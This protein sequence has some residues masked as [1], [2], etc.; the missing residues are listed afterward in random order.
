MTFG[1]ATADNQVELTNSI[2]LNGQVRQIDVADG[3]GG[4]SLLL[5]GDLIDS[6]GGGGL[7]KTGAGSLILSGWNTYNGPTTIDNG[8][9]TVVSN[10]ALPD[11]TSLTVAAG[12]TLT[13]DPMVV[14]PEPST[15]ALL[16]VGAIGLLAYG[17]RRR[18]HAT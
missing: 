15:L 17:G 12:A 18:G 2:D 3:L 6:S 8:E 7:L 13:F 5:S 16:V 11:A 1:S 14:V 4:D 9:L 10:T